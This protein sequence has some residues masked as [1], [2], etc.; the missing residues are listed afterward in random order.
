MA[1]KNTDYTKVLF[2]H[3]ELEFVTPEAE[4]FMGYVARVSNPRTRTIP[5]WLAS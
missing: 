2:P 3:V 4:R 1:I 5:T